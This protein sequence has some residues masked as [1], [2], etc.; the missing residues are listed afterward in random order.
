MDYNPDQAIPEHIRAAQQAAIE[1]ERRAAAVREERYKRDRV[2]QER[3]EKRQAQEQARRTE[4][5]KAEREELARQ[6]ME[7]E[8]A[9]LRAQ[10]EAA[11]GLEEEWEGFWTRNRDRLLLERMQENQAQTAHPSLYARGGWHSGQSFTTRRV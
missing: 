3:E 8:K 10:F 9:A 11:Y 2:A 1:R 6:H 4:H 7:K 5:L